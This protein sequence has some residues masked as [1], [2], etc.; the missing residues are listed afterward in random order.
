MAIA[1]CERMV[2]EREVRE[3]YERVLR[4]CR[5]ECLTKRDRRDEGTS[6]G[7]AA[8]RGLNEHRNDCELNRD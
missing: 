4:E 3:G 7:S 2:S 1:A 6:V 5:V 8:K